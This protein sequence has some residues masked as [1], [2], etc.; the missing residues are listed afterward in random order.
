MRHKDELGHIPIPVSLRLKTD[1]K[2]VHRDRE[3]P[4]PFALQ[5]AVDCELDGW[6]AQGMVVKDLPGSG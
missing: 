6:E 3:R 5:E 2:L 4:L 1:A